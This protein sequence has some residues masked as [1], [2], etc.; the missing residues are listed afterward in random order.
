MENPMNPLASIRPPV[1]VL[2]L[3][4]WVALVSM[5][6]SPALAGL[7]A[8]GEPSFGISGYFK[9]P[10]RLGQATTLLVRIW[11]EGS[12]DV[13]VT[14]VARISVPEGIRVISGDTVSIAHVNQWSRKRAERLIPIVIRP[15]RPGRYLIRG[16]LGIDAGPD[17]GADETD[18][19]LSAILEQDTVAYSRAPR[20]TRFENVRHGQ[21]Y[22][23]AGRYLVPID[24]TQALLEEEITSKAKPRSQEEATCPGC[25]GPL[26]TAIP[27]VVMVGS[28]GT[29]RESRFL[30]MQEEGTTD[31]SLVAA[32]NQ[33]LQRWEFSAAQ[34]GDRAVADFLVVRVPV[35]GSP[36]P[37]Q[38]PVEDA[39]APAPTGA[40]G[41][42]EP[43]AGTARDGEP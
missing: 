35:M 32:A 23:Y 9:T 30:D 43:P 14:S 26:P 7:G 22:R 8:E 42:G 6:A 5:A 21:R 36:S 28:D 11:G 41:D 20:V 13:P 34:A 15:E 19:F 24:S 37:P 38:R 4:A 1:A 33:A 40:A 16:W 2:V 31:P 27:F 39:P 25:P 29:I 17:H 18:F 3:F 12:Y 10:P